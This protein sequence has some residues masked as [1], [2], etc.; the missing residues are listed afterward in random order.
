MFRITRFF[1]LQ[2]APVIDLNQILT[3]PGFKDRKCTKNCMF[4]HDKGPMSV[5]IRLSYSFVYF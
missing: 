1:L 2:T 4:V 3:G 5:F